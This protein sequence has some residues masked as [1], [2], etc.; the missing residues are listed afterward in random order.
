MM[1]EIQKPELE[2]LILDRMQKGGFASIEDALMQALEA[3]P[4]VA[5]HPVKSRDQRTGADLIAALQ[6]SP[7]RELDIEPSR[8]RLSMPA[9]DVTF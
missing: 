1:I 5:E 8:F 6:A 9:R 4:M 7:Y 3:S 2:A